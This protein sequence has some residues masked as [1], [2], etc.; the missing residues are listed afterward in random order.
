MNSIYEQVKGSD[1]V[2]EAMAVDEGNAFRGMV[3][4]GAVGTV[5]AAGAAGTGKGGKNFNLN[6]NLDE[7]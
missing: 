6:F 2:A 3:G 7:E 5:G 1:S 4:A